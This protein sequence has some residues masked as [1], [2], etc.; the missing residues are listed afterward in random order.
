MFARSGALLLA[1]TASSPGHSLRLLDKIALKTTTLGLVWIEQGTA[2]V[3]AK[4]MGRGA[5]NRLDRVRIFYG[6]Y[7]DTSTISAYLL[8]N[9]SNNATR[10]SM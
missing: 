1:H 7:L 9:Q 10:R 4:R 8:P 5:I 3:R 6:S 2:R